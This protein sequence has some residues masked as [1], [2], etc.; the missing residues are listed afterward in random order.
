M[1]P[2]VFPDSFPSFARTLRLLHQVE[3]SLDFSKKR[4]DEAVTKKTGEFMVKVVGSE[5]QGVLGNLRAEE[6]LELILPAVKKLFSD[7]STAITSAWL[8]FDQ[9]ARVLGRRATTRHLLHHILFCYDGEGQTSKH[10]KL[11]HRTFLQILIVRFGTGAFLRYFATYLIEAVGGYKDYEDD[12]SR[13]ERQ[14][15]SQCTFSYGVPFCFR[16]VRQGLERSWRASES[17]SSR[18]GSSLSDAS[19]ENN[20]SGAAGAP[21]DEETE[22]SR[23]SVASSNKESVTEDPLAEGE[24]FAFDNVSLSG[25]AGGGGA[26][27]TSSDST[28]EVFVEVAKGE[29]YIPPVRY[30]MSDN[31]EEVLLRSGGANNSGGNISQVQD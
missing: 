31:E 15:F 1:S 5:L 29:I 8:I 17:H 18:P 27:P 4:G 25:E 11:Y 26:A 24:V 7:P 28:S 20:T 6:E 10:L 23:R 12:A 30:D 3:E 14:L 2:V 21:R 13:Q 16:P 22:V 9:L 19:S